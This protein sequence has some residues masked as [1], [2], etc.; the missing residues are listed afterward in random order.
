MTSTFFSAMSTSAF[1]QVGQQAAYQVDLAAQPQAHVGG[2]LVVAAA[3][4]VQALAGVAHQLGQ[5]RLDVE[6]HVFEVQLPLKGAGL[7]LAGDLR[8]ALLDVGVVGGGNDFLRGQHLGVGER[9][10]NVGLP[11][12]L[13]KEHAGRVALDQV[14]HGLG[15]EGRPGLGLFVELVHVKGFLLRQSLLP[16][17]P[18]IQ[19][20]Y[21]LFRAVAQAGGPK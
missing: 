13:V 21:A 5:A 12:A 18:W 19:G 9:A 1:L 10:G 7:D 6:V 3:A 20:T 14:A 2:D 16:V 15:K 8:H 17:W 4:G 11:Q